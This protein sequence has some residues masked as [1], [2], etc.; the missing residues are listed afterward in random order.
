MMQPYYQ[1]DLVTLYHGDCREL[2]PRMADQSVDVV[3]TDP[4]Y[5]ARTHSMTRSNRG[6]YGTSGNGNR[7]LSGHS[8]QFGAWDHSAQLDLFGELARITRRWVISSLASD[9]AFRFEVDQP[10]DGLRVLRIGAWIKTNPMPIISADRPAMGWEPIAYM[11]RVDVKPT[12]NGGGRA[13]NYV[14]PLSQG[15]GH[16]TQKPIDMVR[17]WVRKFS[18]RGD[19]V[20]DPFMGTGTTIRAAVDEGRR[21]IGIELDERWCEYT[22]RR[23]D[24]QTLDFGSAV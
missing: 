24:Q 16:A 15:S 13:A 7:T 23:L 21:A 9:T 1:D 11:H 20:L 6:G 18:D 8:A 5:D 2:L 4:P 14:L 10:P 19:T 12:W 22:A 3:I 17:D